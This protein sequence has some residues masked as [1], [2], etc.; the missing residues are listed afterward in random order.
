MYIV[1]AVL[2][3]GGLFVSWC[4]SKPY[5]KWKREQDKGSPRCAH[6]DFP[7][8]HPD[9]PYWATLKVPN[10]TRPLPKPLTWT[11]AYCMTTEQRDE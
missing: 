3:F 1:M 6:C 7:M 11:C 8:R 10:T 4:E 9:N 2:F 5:P